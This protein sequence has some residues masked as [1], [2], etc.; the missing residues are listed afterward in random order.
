VPWSGGGGGPNVLNK[1]PWTK[2][3]QLS[4]C[5]KIPGLSLSGGR[6]YGGS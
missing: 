2:K 5:F 3:R 1:D 6:K 4:G